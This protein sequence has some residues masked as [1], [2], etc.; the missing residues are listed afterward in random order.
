MQEIFLDSYTFFTYFFKINI[1]RIHPNT[2]FL[3]SKEE[4]NQLIRDALSGKQSAF[5]ALLNR[6]KNGIYN[7]IYQMIKNR[8]E[9]E[10]LVQETF[11]KAFHSL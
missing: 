8:E 9:A 4:I 1:F 6:Y 10:D 5:E 2:W 11:I 3:L 7:M